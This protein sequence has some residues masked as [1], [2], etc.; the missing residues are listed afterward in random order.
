VLLI[1]DLAYLAPS[2][3]GIGFL[4]LFTGLPVYLAWRRGV[5][6]AAI[7]RRGSGG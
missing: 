4:I 2:T 1:L 5:G 7:G 3:S 6:A